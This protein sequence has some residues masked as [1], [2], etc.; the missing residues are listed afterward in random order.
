MLDHSVFCKTHFDPRLYTIV[1]YYR[2]RHCTVSQSP[3]FCWSIYVIKLAPVLK[4]HVTFYFN[5]TLM[6]SN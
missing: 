2:L 1:F 6:V 5:S 4:L 3:V